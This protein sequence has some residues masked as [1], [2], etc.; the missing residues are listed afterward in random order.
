MHIALISF[1]I[2]YACDAL[3]FGATNVVQPIVQKE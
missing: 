1:L 3:L 2:I